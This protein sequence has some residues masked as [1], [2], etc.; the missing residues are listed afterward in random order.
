MGRGGVGHD[1]VPNS[2]TPPPKR[3]LPGPCRVVRAVDIDRTVRVKASLRVLPL[4]GDSAA[5]NMAADE[6]LLDAEL[7]YRPT[8][9]FYEWTERAVS[10]GTAQR[11]REDLRLDRIVE[12]GIALVRRASG[13]TAIYHH[14]QLGISLAIENGHGLNS[15]DITESYRA[16]GQ[17]LADAFG[18]LGINAEPISVAKAREKRIDGPMNRCCLAGANPYEPFAQG[19]KVAGFAQIRRRDV[20]LI[21]AVIPLRFEAANWASLLESEPWTQSKLVENLASTVAGL[22]TITGRDIL[23]GDVCEAVCAGF[24]AAGFALEKGRLSAEERQLA[25][26]LHRDKYS[27]ATWTYRL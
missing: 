18:G 2:L 9:R 10:I 26:R 6:A 20:S 19:R 27:D 4:A 15:P 12:S 24:E 22:D 11:V 3:L 17:L 13:G 14:H 5:W 21:H 23:A 16:F 8:L 25:L 7:Y 1:T